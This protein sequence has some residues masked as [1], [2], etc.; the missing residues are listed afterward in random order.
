MT[1]R[2][3]LENSVST[4][5]RLPDTQARGAGDI[6]RLKCFE[7]DS[8]KQ[9]MNRVGKLQREQNRITEC[10]YETAAEA[11]MGYPSKTV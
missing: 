2:R 7:H 4:E 9:E 1:D 3:T 6:D 11:L 8:Y 5:L 10:G